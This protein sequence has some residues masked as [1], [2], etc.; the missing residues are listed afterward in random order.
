LYLELN[1]DY[2]NQLFG[3]NETTCE[4]ESDKYDL[5]DLDDVTEQYVDLT[6]T[7]FMK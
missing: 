6:S 1:A 3:K 7:D 4:N 2:L 5:I